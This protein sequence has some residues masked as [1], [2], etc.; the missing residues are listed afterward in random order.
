M[1]FSRSSASS[2]D[3]RARQILEDALVGV[4]QVVKV[5]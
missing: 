1:T 3:A 4:V 2:A 5:V